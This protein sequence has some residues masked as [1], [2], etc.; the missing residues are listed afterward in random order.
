[1]K[2][3]QLAI[4][5]TIL[6]LLFPVSGWG[7]SDDEEKVTAIQNRIFYKHHEL[8]VS[9]GYIADDD[10][11]HVYP[12]AASYTYNYNE[13]LSLEVLRFQYM[14]TQDKD[15][16][17]ELLDIGV[18]PSRYPEQKYAIHSHLIFKPLYGKDAVLNRGIVNHETYVFVGG[19]VVRYEWIRSYGEN[20]TEDAPSLSL[21][22][23]MKFFLNQKFCLN[24]EI[25]D[26]MNFRE[27]DTENNVF[28]GIGIGFRFDLSPRETK[29]DPTV[30]KL[31]N[32]LN[33]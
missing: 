24:V 10:F 30:E 11:S 3:K 27:D 4:L 7:A 14:F 31:R 20:E 29:E 28:F 17:A 6:G 22:V 2:T 9:A 12:I 32:I 8:G 18:Q 33:Q 5:F 21:G 13:H 26:L 23:G 1:M 19:G 25:R 16:K 15:L